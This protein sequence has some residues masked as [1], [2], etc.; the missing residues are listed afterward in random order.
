MK[1]LI[2]IFG[3]CGAFNADAQNFQYVEEVRDSTTAIE[4]TDP[5]G[6]QFQVFINEFGEFYI[7]RRSKR[8]GYYYRKHLKVTAVEL[9][10]PK[11]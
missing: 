5:S 2:L 7:Q 10:Q 8:T 9:K 11:F 4:Y 6:E 3:L 1:K